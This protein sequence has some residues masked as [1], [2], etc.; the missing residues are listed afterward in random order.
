MTEGKCP[1]D[2]AQE[3]VAPEIAPPG[4]MHATEA[5]S[6][7]REEEVA[8][9]EP[10]VS[11]KHGRRGNDR[12]DANAPPKVLRKDYASVRPEH[13]THGRKSLS[14]KGLA[15]G[16]TFIPPADTKR[17][18]DP[19]PLS[20]TSDLKTLLEVETG[21]KKAAETKSADL[22]KELESHHSHILD[23]QVSHDQLTQQVSTLQAQVTGEEK[24]KATFEEFKKYEDDRVEKRCAE[25]D[26]RL[27]ALSID[28]DKELYPHML[29]VITGRGWVIGYGLRLAVM[30]C[31]ESIEL[32]QVFADV[33]FTRIA[34][35]MSEGLKYEVEHGKANLDLE[36]IEAYDLEAETKYVA[37]LHALKDLKYLM[38]IREL[39][40]SSSQL[41]I[42]VYSEVRDPKDP[43]AFKEEI[44]LANVIAAN[45]S[46]AEKKKKR[47]VVC[48][49]HGVGSAHNARSDGVP[50]ICTCGVACAPWESSRMHLTS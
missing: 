32:R 48:R 2:Q 20:Y 44:L 21:M 17:V 18:N 23:L 3:T 31:G 25:I 6:E 14:M 16:V 22:T 5:A 37:A 40:P 24:L 43:W 35:G 27:D 28:F 10:R 12:A 34:I 30:K 29:T 26:A 9:L 15:A 50:V 11:K 7:G 47:R 39:R 13:S 8:A 4:S 38:W 19:E 41:K 49:T 42:L 36:A 1:E 46:R 33:V 45:I